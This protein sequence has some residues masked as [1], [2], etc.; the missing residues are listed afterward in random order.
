GKYQVSLEVDDGSNNINSLTKQVRVGLQ[1]APIALTQVYVNGIEQDLE[2]SACIEV[3]RKDSVLFDAGKSVSIRGE[4]SGISYLWQ[5]EDFDEIYRSRSFT[6]IFNELTEGGCIDVDLTVQDLSTSQEDQAETISIEVVNMPPLLTDVRYSAPQQLI[7][8]PVTVSVSALGVRDPDGRVV[9]YR[10]WYYEEGQ[11]GRELDARVTDAP[12]TTF[13][14]G[15]RGVEGTQ[16]NYSFAVEIEDNDGARVSSFTAEGDSEPLVVTNGPNVAPVAEFVVDKGTVKVNELVTFSSTT[17]DP[18]GEFIPS[19]AYQWD[20]QGDGEYERD[21][22]G[23]RV[24]YRYPQPGVYRPTLKVTKNGLSSQ[25]DMTLHVRADSVPPEAAFIFIQDGV[26]V[27]FISNSTVDPALPDKNLSYAWDFDTTIDTNGNGINDDDADSALITPIHEFEGNR[28]VLVGLR[29]RDSVGVSDQVVRRIPFLKQEERGPLGTKLDVKLKAVLKTNPPRDDID[30]RLYL[31]PPSSDV[32]FNSLT[33]TGQIQEY[34]LDT[35]I[36]VDSD[37]DEITDNDIDNKTHKSWKDG[38][39][40]KATYRDTQGQIR[41]KLTVVAINGQEKSA[42]VDITFDE[43]PDFNLN[44]VDN[45]DAV[46]SLLE[47]VPVVTFTVS[48]SFAEPQQEILFDA[49]GTHFPDEAVQEYRWDFDGDGLVDEISFEPTFSHAYPQVG[50]YEVVLEA[51]SARG[52]IGE[53]TQTV[54]IRG[55]LTLPVA[56]FEYVLSENEVV[57]TNTSTIDA[58]LNPELTAYEWSFRRLNVGDI[59]EW[60]QW[61]QRDDLTIGVRE[62]NQPSVWVKHSLDLAAADVAQGVMPREAVLGSQNLVLRVTEGTTFLDEQ[63]QP[64]VGTLVFELSD[65]TFIVEG[66]DTAL[67]YDTGLSQSLELSQDAEIL[68]NGVIF[69]PKLYQ[70]GSSGVPVFVSEGRVEDNITHFVISSFGG[71][72]LV[73][74]SVEAAEGRDGELLGIS[75]L[76]EPVKVLDIAGLYQVTLTIMDELGEIDQ[77]QQLI[78]IDQDLT[79]RQ[80]GDGVAEEEIVPVPGEDITPVI[81]VSE[82]IPDA[83]G[84]SIFWIIFVIVIVLG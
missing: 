19:A 66:E 13:V 3:T 34:R 56:D 81:P 44:Q 64:F 25:Y 8:T 84:L 74:G 21:L 30:G 29:V 40:F 62:F 50:A 83:G 39:S 80:P 42:V 1:N 69:S 57:F 37:S 45:P 28:D 77:K 23:A 72:Y 10:W 12:R 67:V 11:G 16:T 14:I 22:S 54:F 82:I 49:R 24:N 36:F 4:S 20:V 33:S 59:L 58:S 35:N 38:S 51:V 79:I 60:E 68:F 2:Q 55:G 52:L 73:T 48:S 46:L 6:R 17:K 63:A 31:T 7:V 18:L 76:P 65:Q 53:Y 70:V 78:V 26:Q 32:V 61:E 5:I 75:T 47:T 27:R 9:R 15:P 43:K 41:A 71:R